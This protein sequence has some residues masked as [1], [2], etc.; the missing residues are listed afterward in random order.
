MKCILSQVLC[1]VTTLLRQCHV[2]PLHIALQTLVA[3]IMQLR[4][5]ST[6][7]NYIPDKLQEALAAITPAFARVQKPALLCQVK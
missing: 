1:R 7:L 4:S 2:Q 5:Q 6:P 3:H